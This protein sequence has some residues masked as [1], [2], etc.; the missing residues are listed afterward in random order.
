LPAY[1]FN[2]HH[3]AWLIRTVPTLGM[4]VSGRS[5]PRLVYYIYCTCLKP[6]YLSYQIPRE[7]GSFQPVPPSSIWP[8]QLPIL[9]E[10]TGVAGATLRAGTSHCP[11][12]NLIAKLQPRCT[13]VS[14][15][16]LLPHPRARRL[17]GKLGPAIFEIK[18]AGCNSFGCESDATKYS[19]QIHGARGD[20]HLK[21][22]WTEPASHLE[23]LAWHALTP[24]Q[25]TI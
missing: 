19:R 16:Y 4:S 22:G 8:A 14:S 24:A 15:G 9:M 20:L 23:P 21:S 2:A 13:W 11:G 17:T 6:P 1:L 18:V 5:L 10:T 12:H 25:R 3:L 7:R